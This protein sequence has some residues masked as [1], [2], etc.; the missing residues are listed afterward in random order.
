[1][2]EWKSLSY[3][4][5]SRENLQKYEIL[6]IYFPGILYEFQRY[7]LR[8]PIIVSF[9]N[10][11][12]QFLHVTKVLLC[13]KTRLPLKMPFSTLR[14]LCY[15]HYAEKRKIRPKNLVERK[16]SAVIIM[17]AFYALETLGNSSKKGRRTDYTQP[18]DG[19][20][21]ILWGKKRTRFLAIYS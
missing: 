21:P 12:W 18:T 13:Y 5:F 9:S 14:K 2:I 10:V 19:I 7:F 3:T 16:C 20:Y 6:S 1:M 8:N 15:S 11:D 17:S 4:V